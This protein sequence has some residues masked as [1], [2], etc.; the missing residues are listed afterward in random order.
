LMNVEPAP[1]IVM[2]GAGF[3]DVQESVTKLATTSQRAAARKRRSANMG[4]P[5]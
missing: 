2:L 3:F 1:M 4:V 5:P